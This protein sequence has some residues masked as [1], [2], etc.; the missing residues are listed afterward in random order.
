[1]KQ[2]LPPH[3]VDSGERMSPTYGLPNITT[4]LQN[5]KDTCKH[6]LYLS[7]HTQANSVFYSKYCLGDALCQS[8]S[9][10]NSLDDLK[11]ITFILD[12]FLDTKCNCAMLVREAFA[13]YMFVKRLGFYI[14]DTKCTILFNHRLPEKSSK[15][16]NGKE[17]S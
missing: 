1:M 10:N 7:T 4:T 8:I 12:K 6:H 14:P 5:Q 11:S 2:I 13:I 15:R 16:K 17:Q 9:K 3:T